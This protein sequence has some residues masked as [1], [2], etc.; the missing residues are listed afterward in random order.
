[1]WP[2][3]VYENPYNVGRHLRRRGII[4]TVLGTWVQREPPDDP[5]S[6]DLKEYGFSGLSSIPSLCHVGVARRGG[7]PVLIALLK[8][9]A[10]TDDIVQTIN[11]IVVISSR[12]QEDSK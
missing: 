10:T 5:L 12:I 3:P 1:M 2:T 11:E 6:D 8:R 4:G 7:S 9:D